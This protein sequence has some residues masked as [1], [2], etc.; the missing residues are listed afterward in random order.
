MIDCRDFD[1]S[2]IV[3]PSGSETHGKVYVPLQ[4]KTSPSLT[5]LFVAVSIPA[6]F[7]EKAP[8]LTTI[9]CSLE[10]DF[11]APKGNVKIKWDANARLCQVLRNL[12]QKFT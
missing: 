8:V 11:K 3:G 1:G 4:L 9:P 5:P 12:H 7:P 2:Q 10:H 6:R